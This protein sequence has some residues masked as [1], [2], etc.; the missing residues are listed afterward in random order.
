MQVGF[1]FIQTKMCIGKWED[2][3][4]IALK[5]YFFIE[6]LTLLLTRSYKISRFFFNNIASCVGDKKAW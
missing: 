5:I 2:G 4:N 3:I 6:I 1:F